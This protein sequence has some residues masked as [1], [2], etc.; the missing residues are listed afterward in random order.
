[1]IPGARILLDTAARHFAC[2]RPTWT[3]RG[4][5]GCE[6]VGWYALYR[7]GGPTGMSQVDF[8]SRFRLQSNPGVA[9]PHSAAYSTRP[10]QEV[11]STEE[12]VRG[13]AR[14][15]RWGRTIGA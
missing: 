10:E 3:G 11:V 1:V 8:G 13:S 14:D 6:W 7:G 15:E 12:Q 5:L 4:A 2:F 9:H